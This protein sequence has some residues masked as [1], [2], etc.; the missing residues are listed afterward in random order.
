VLRAPGE[1]MRRVPAGE[2]TVRLVAENAARLTRLVV[3]RVPEVMVYMFEGL[4]EPSPPRWITHSWGFLEE[5]ILPSTNLIVSP[6]SDAYA[7][8]ARAWQERGG[9]WLI[10]QSMNPL[11]REGADG[12]AYWA[13]VLGDER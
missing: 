3:R 6:P 7:D 12:A 10:N 2:V 4:E 11:R 5:A 9:R 13:N 1:I 8:H